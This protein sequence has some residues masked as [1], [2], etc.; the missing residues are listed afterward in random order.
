MAVRAVD[1]AR[2]SGM[3]LQTLR[4]AKLLGLLRFAE[5]AVMRVA[6]VLMTLHPLLPSLSK[7]LDV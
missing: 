5:C 4:S 1:V 6:L 7:R 2:L 3:A